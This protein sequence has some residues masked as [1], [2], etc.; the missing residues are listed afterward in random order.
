[1][2]RLALAKSFLDVQRT[3]Q[4]VARPGTCLNA[5]ST[6]KAVRSPK[7]LGLRKISSSL[8]AEMS[9]ARRKPQP[10]SR[11]LPPARPRQV[12][13]APPAIRREKRPR[14]PVDILHSAEPR[15][16]SDPALFLRVKLL[17]RPEDDLH[18]HVRQRSSTTTSGGVSATISMISFGVTTRNSE[19]KAALNTPSAS[20]TTQRIKEPSST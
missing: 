13:H 4:S 18:P 17:A 8:V 10:R 9:T 11:R 3:Y 20:S 12:P 1:M 14:A 2:P 5:R 6:Q 16:T 15:S 19:R 7:L